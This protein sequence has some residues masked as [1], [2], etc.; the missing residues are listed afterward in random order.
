MV[1]NLQPWGKFCL[2][3]SLLFLAATSVHYLTRPYVA[4]FVNRTLNASVAAQLINTVSPQANVQAVGSRV[5]SGA[6]YIQVAQGCEGID[7]MLMLV[8]AVLTF[9]VSLS[10]K[11]IGAVVGAF[12][13]YAF[14]LIRIV[15]LWYCLRHWPEGFETMHL[16]V[17]Q[18]MLI[19]VGLIFF[20]TWARPF[21]DARAQP[22]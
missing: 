14:N 20:A 4:P 1:S 6:T 18:T 17:G 8:A 16:I 7:V 2:H 12:A 11:L 21:G 9:P 10:R 13:I 19:L 22:V 3:F 5:G 15:G